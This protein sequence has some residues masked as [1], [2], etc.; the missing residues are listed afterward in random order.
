MAYKLQIIG[1]ALI[2]LAGGL[3]YGLLRLF[4]G[5]LRPVEVEQISERAWYAVTETCL[6][7]TLFREEIGFAFVLML[8]GLLFGKVWQWI[9]ELRVQYLQQ[10]QEPANPRLFHFRLVSSLLL[11]IFADVI[12]VTSCLSSVVHDARMG[13]AL[14]F[15]F[16]WAILTISSVAQGF[17][18]VFC[19]IDMRITKEQPAIALEEKKK[20][21]K[22]ARERAE[23]EAAENGTA[24]DPS[25]PH[26]DHIDENDVDVPGWENKGMYTFGLDVVMGKCLDCTLGLC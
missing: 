17:H 8:L 10:Q 22:E 16:E 13:M 20:E 1:H 9:I 26:E 18:Y 12:M 4:F 2:L 7:M 3:M 15:M 24:V 21:V 23:R 25:L 19:T 11:S 6:A 5:H 14:M